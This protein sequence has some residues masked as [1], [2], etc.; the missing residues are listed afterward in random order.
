MSEPI[1]RCNGCET[2]KPHTSFSRDGLYL[3]S[4][5]KPCRR[6]VNLNWHFNNPVRAQANRRM[7]YRKNRQAEITKS[8]AYNVAH[9]EIYRSWTAANLPKLAEKQRAKN[10]R[11][12]G[13]TPCW[14]SAIHR[15]QISEF[16]E[17]AAA[18]GTQTGVKCHVDHIVPLDG[19]WFSG[20][21]VPWNLQVLEA[22]KNTAKRNKVP[23]D[24][25][26]LFWEAT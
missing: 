8:M 18:R 16:Y 12:L 21:H 20:L 14:L 6:V 15:A 5:C 24:L 4:R 11:K 1:K 23:T 3:R 17:I 26:H 13:A 19:K 2:E 7:I 22:A 10:A 25:A 9:P